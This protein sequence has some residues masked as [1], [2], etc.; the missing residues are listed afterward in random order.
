MSVFAKYKDTFLD[1]AE[2]R[3]KSPLR[4]PLK[5]TGA[6]FNDYNRGD[7]IVVGGRKTSGKSSFILNNYVISPFYQKR[8]L[9]KAKKPSFDIKVVYISAR[10]NLKMTMEKMMVNYTA[11][12]N[13][14]SRISIPALYGGI[15]TNLSVK[16]AQKHISGS[17][18]LFDAVAKKGYLH[19]HTGRKSVFEVEEL[20]T[21]A[22]SELGS[23]NDD[24]GSFE[25]EEG[26]E[27]TLPIIVID[28]ASSIY[29]DTC[30]NAL[31]NEASSLLAVKLQQIAKVY[32]A[33]VVLAVPSTY[34][35]YNKRSSDGHRSSAEEIKPF[36][37]YADRTIILH[38]PAET[39]E[40]SMLGYDVPSFVHP[41][42]GICYIR[43][44]TV[45]SNYLGA[46]GVNLG[47]FIYP[48]NG[49]MIDLPPAEESELL[50][51]FYSKAYEGGVSSKEDDHM[52]DI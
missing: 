51:A 24:D 43:T 45:I 37:K 21:S 16:E 13:G 11:N 36:D 30:D 1:L 17:L 4:F 26:K 33:L 8:M 49:Y 41:V 15:G 14:G 18:N 12:F 27:G 25:Y 10:R 32:N 2:N 48:E 44:A 46:S 22:M 23:L 28:D 50:E 29:S 3:K 39:D 42:T 9:L 31:N 7:F 5:K 6:L 47:Y 20:I 34:S 38:N 40:K 52:P 35:Y 19:L